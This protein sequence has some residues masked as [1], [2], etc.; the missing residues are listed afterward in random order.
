[1]LGHLIG[2][3]S[4]LCGQ[5]LRYCTASEENSRLVTQ[6]ATEEFG[7]TIN[8]HAGRGNWHQLVPSGNGN[9][10]HPAGVKLRLRELGIFGQRSYEKRIPASVFCLDHR[11]IAVLL[12]HLWATDGTIFARKPGTRGSSTI[13]FSTNSRGLARDVAALL[14]R[15]GI[16][17]R[18]R[19]VAQGEHRPMF[20]VSVSGARDQTIFLE[21]VEAFGP[22]REGAEKLARLLA[23]RRARPMSGPT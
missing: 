6:A 4:Y 2:D 5:P 19:E 11:S 1:M 12:K 9:R 3:G 15:L 16:V 10:W 21:R 17:G 18:V 13:C 23:T 22:R 14:L 8:R 7:V 20:T